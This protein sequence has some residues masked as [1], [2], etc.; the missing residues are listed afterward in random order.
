VAASDKDL[1][2]AVSVGDNGLLAGVIALHRIDWQ[3]RHAWI[4]IVLGERSVWGQGYATEAMP[5]VTG[6]AFHELG[7][8]KVLASVYAGN[9][10][11]I[12]MAEK[13][14]YRQCGLLRRNAF[15]GGEWHDEWLGEILRDEWAKPG[16]RG[17]PP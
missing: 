10:R 2:W 3:H 7:L 4:E 5:L 11:S 14:G 13:Q 6:H 1:V 16:P 15:F 17:G 12:R 9:E 8:E